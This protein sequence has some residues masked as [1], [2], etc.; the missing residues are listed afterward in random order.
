MVQE[1]QVFA[2]AEHTAQPVAQ[3]E[4]VLGIVISINW[5]VGQVVAQV[6]VVKD[7]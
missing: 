6:L 5:P 4:Q 1:V 2:C 7:L 3:E